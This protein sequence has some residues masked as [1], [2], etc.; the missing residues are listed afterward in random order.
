M[1]PNLALIWPLVCIGLVDLNSSACFDWIV[2]DLYPLPPV[3]A[4][5]ILCLG[6][7]LD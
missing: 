3:S 4:L 6:F 2:A 5:F 7:D 1:S